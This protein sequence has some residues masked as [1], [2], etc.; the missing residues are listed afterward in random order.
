M[1]QQTILVQ[2]D[3]QTSKTMFWGSLWTAIGACGVVITSVLYAIA[4][5]LAALP[6]PN[7]S[8]AAAMQATI[9]GQFWMTAAG[10]VG[11]LADVAMATGSFVLMVAGQR[12]RNG[13]ETAGWAWMAIT[14]I[15]FILV[16]SLL[17][18]VLGPIAVLGGP[19]TAY[20]GFK[21]VFDICF[22]LGTMTFGMGS[23]SILLGQL[24]VDS[25]LIPRTFGI[26]G[27]ISAAIGIASAAGYLVG[28]DLAPVI[29]VSIG[30]GAILFTV[31]G[32][33][34]LR[35]GWSTLHHGNL[36]CRIPM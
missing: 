26:L 23:I 19:M 36:A 28:I 12:N 35:A 17:S 24:R 27:I 31:I 5:P 29:G 34:M 13:L 3:T 4:P 8:I 1:E 20:V 21:H 9:A 15:I 10:N 14:N 18:H 7:A 30:I 16:D 2:T 6:I 11:I 32:I 33:Q 22:I 25:L